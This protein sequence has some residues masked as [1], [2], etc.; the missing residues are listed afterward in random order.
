MGLV[1]QV[2]N[3]TNRAPLHGHSG[4]GHTRYATAGSSILC[5]ARPFLIETFHG[6]LAVAHNGNLT[7]AVQLRR[8]LLQR[9]VGLISTTDTEV[10]TQWSLSHVHSRQDCNPSKPETTR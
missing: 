4:I 5:N 1:A 7:N 3:K 10:I 2:F 9:D 6:P 8:E